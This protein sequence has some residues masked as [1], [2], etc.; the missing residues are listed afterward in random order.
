MK[1]K[2]FRAATMPQALLLVK[3]ELGAQAVI[4]WYKQGIESAIE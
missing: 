2:T 1:L 4:E 3:R